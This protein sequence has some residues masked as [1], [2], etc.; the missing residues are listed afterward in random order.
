[1]RLKVARSRIQ[2]SWRAPHHASAWRYYINISRDS[3][4]AEPSGSTTGPLGEAQFGRGQAELGLPEFRR[5][6]K[7]LQ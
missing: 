4:Y 3:P 2:F 1:M 5:I 6:M 7:S